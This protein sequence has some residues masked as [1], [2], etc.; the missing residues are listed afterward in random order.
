MHHIPND[1]AGYTLY[2]RCFVWYHF[3]ATIPWSGATW[4]LGL[5]VHTADWFE[6]ILQRLRLLC[7]WPGRHR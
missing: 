7:S 3:V 5:G 1:G 6:N 2:Q 4:S